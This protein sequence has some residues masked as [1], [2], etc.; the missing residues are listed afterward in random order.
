MISSLHPKVVT[1]DRA[2]VASKLRSVAA[3][4]QSRKINAPRWAWRMIP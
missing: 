2:P 1:D 3:F 4:R